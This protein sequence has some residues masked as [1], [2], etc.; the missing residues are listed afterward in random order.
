MTIVRVAIRYHGACA[1]E[2]ELNL[3]VIT[4][5]EPGGGSNE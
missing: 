1:R 5:A 3:P 2:F 4:L